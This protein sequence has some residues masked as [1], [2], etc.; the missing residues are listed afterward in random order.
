M[1]DSKHDLLMRNT[2][3]ISAKGDSWAPLSRRMAW[4]YVRRRDQKLILSL[5]E[6]WLALGDPPRIFNPLLS[7]VGQVGETT[8][9]YVEIFRMCRLENLKEKPTDITVGSDGIA[10]LTTKSREKIMQATLKIYPDE[11]TYT[12]LGRFGVSE[13]SSSHIWHFEAIST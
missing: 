13:L 4:T 5:G 11:Q 3:S 1:A 9:E 2:I 8:K 10:K 6:P 7:L 12:E